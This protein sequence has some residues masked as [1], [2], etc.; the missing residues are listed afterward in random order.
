MLKIAVLGCA[1]LAP[2][3]LGGC[4]RESA[5][6]AQ[7]K[8]SAAAAALDRSHKGSELPDLVFADPAGDKLD[9]AALKGKPILLN[10]WATWCAPCLA[11]MPALDK[12]AA[13]KSDAL[14]VVTISQDLAQ[15][16]KVAAFF[17]E[18]KLAR[19]EPWLD[20][21]NRLSDHYAANTL[22]TTVLYDSAGREVWRFTGP[23][24][25]GDA[26]TAGLLAEAQ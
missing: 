4:D 3:A 17:K 25:W 15:P 10:L 18:R 5:P 11:E 14:Q 13:E 1:L 6:P 21:E 22:P 19:L 2:F 20:P 9:L 16:E 26:E 23:R 24:E 8:E 7:P 12:L